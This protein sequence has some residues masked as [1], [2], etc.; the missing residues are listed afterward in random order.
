MSKITRFVVKT[1]EEMNFYQIEAKPK[2]VILSRIYYKHTLS[3]QV[4]FSFTRLL[5]LYNNNAY[6]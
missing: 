6:K 2:K 1:G 4:V 3:L 5:N